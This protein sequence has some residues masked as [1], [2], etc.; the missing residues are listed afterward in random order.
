[1]QNG[2][3]SPEGRAKTVFSLAE[4]GRL[5]LVDLLTTVDLLNG[6]GQK[7]KAIALY[8]SWIEHASSPLAYVACF[9]LGVILAADREHRQ[10][11]AMYCQA[12]EQNPDFLQGRL[13]LGNTLE[14]QGRTDEALEQWRKVLT[15]KTIDQ[16]ENKPLCL[17]A[18][19]NLGRLLEVKKQ[20]R[21]ALQM[22]QKSF[23]LDPTQRDVLLHLVHL[24]QKVCQWPVYRPPK[25]TTRQKMI[26]GTSPLA[27]L[28]AFDDP[29]LQLTAA[30]QFIEYKY[31]VLEDVLPPVA[32]YGHD[33][34]R[35]AYLSS[36]FCL[37]A[38]SLLTVELYELH[39]RECFEVYGFC[40]SREDGSPLR[41]RVIGAMDHFIRIG[42][43]SDKEAAECIRSHEIDIVVDLQGLTSGAR[44]LI[45][46]YRPAPVQVAYLGFPGTSGLP[47]IDYVIADE[48]VLPPALTPFF[49]E[50]PIYLPTCFQVSDS[51]REVGPKPTRAENGLPED[52][53][54]FCSFNNNYKFTPEVFA[55]WMRILKAAPKSVFWL[56][57]DNEWA[58]ENICAEAKKHGIA[59]ERLIF[60]PRVAPP[61]YLARYQLADLFLDTFPFNG[62]TTANDALWMGLPLLTCSG[63]TF[64]SRMAGSL[65]KSLGLPELITSSWKEYE[66]RALE[67]TR[68]P[69]KLAEIKH[70]L[71]LAK[72]AGGVFDVMQLTRQIESEFKRLVN[73]LA[74]TPARISVAKPQE[75]LD[76]PPAQSTQVLP[77]STA[78]SKVLMPETTTEKTIAIA[79]IQRDRGPWIVEWLAFHM[80]A[81]FN[82]FYIYS[83]KCVDDMT[84][85]L[86]KL[87][88]HYPIV[89]HE[90]SSDDRPQL[91]C[92]QHAYNAYGQHVDWMAYIDGDEFL[93]PTAQ[94]QM[95]DA[96]AEF[97]D[98][99]L[100]A[101]AAF[102]VCY[103]SSG[104]LKE[105]EG[106]IVENYKRHSGPEFLPN[107]HIKS[108][109]RG[110]Q[111]EVAM[112]GSHLFQTPRGTFDELLR[113][114]YAGWMKEL[115]PTYAKFRINH[116][117]VQS[118]EYFCNS[119]RNIGAA[120]FDSKYVRSNDWYF[121][122]DRNE[123]DDG[124]SYNFLLRLKLKVIELNNAIA[125]G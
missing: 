120:D 19:N 15:V 65:L 112:T 10:A 74:V 48:Y 102:W 32:G 116:Y 69:K 117:P 58:Q 55:S 100:S 93:F 37:H 84:R 114:I 33:K 22:L 8:R 27:M 43:M 99:D 3:M 96:L 108:I 80:L 51:K 110:R 111:D 109:V 89:V 5:E 101:L 53:F 18:L 86:Q 92:Y 14:Q 6:Q 46:A 115:A 71:L 90:I 42:D 75:V 82:K 24:T 123:C 113:P 1:M 85:K 68:Q 35:I 52:A 47:W 122:Y 66:K 106:L 105:P 78:S 98:K 7:D 12:L 67:F 25:G 121:Q 54:V 11:E 49:T 16:P 81:G 13:N 79:S 73:N 119:K 50:K 23:A 60:A 63:R 95:A 125:E 87:S 62:G 21:E 72:A 40:W 118:Y 30:Q 104:Y 45:L 20:Y 88:R 61:D 91:V 70:R 56:L 124:V 29:E 44:P 94:Q 4:Q 31:P 28:A 59:R 2:N 103:G 41:N 64:A 26:Q 9:N 77:G 76:L 107:R 97:E 83:H 39:D 17:H 38:V 34:I 36:D 57:A